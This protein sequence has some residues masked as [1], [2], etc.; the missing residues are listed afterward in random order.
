MVTYSYPTHYF[1]CLWNVL[2]PKKKEEEK[3]VG[4]KEKSRVIFCYG[5]KFIDAMTR[6]NSRHAEPM[7]MDLLHKNLQ[8]VY[9]VVS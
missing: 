2:F 5:Q 7:A 8:R 4:N 1:R 3:S 6:R 9:D